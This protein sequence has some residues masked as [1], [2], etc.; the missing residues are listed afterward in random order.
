MTQL[1][2]WC[3]MTHQGTNHLHRSQITQAIAQ[4]RCAGGAAWLRPEGTDLA[5]ASPRAGEAVMAACKIKSGWEHRT[6]YCS[7]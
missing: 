5:W 4:W 3:S 1:N 2:S 6:K 7:C